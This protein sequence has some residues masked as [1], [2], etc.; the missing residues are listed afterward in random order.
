MAYA[1]LGDHRK[2]EE[3]I[4]LINPI[5]H[6]STPE[7]VDCYK[8]EPYVVAADVYGIA[9]HAGRGG[10]TW[11]TGSAGWMYQLILESFLGLRKDGDDIRFEPC[12][13]A[14][15][16]SFTVRYRFLQ[17]QYHFKIDQN[18]EDGQSGIYVDDVWQTNELVRL[19][20]DGKEHVIV[21]IAKSQF[22]RDT[23]LTSVTP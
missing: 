23:E 22:E 5:H 18:P 6:G 1:K 9:P 14:S 10:W 19:V 16:E 15:W 11:Y 2:T 8:V 4:R 3:L 7:E 12:I 20:N 17:T 21:I 13:P